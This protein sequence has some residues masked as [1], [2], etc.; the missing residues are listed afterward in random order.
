[1]TMYTG[2]FQA[3]LVWGSLNV[4]KIDDAS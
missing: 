2:S 4:N 1:L 3:L